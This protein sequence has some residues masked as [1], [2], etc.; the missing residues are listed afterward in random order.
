MRWII[1]GAVIFVVML[2]AGLAWWHWPEGSEETAE[3]SSEATAPEQPAE[4][5]ANQEEVDENLELQTLAEISSAVAAIQQEIEEETSRSPAQRMTDE[6][7]GLTGSV[8]QM[9][10]LVNEMNGLGDAFSQLTG[11][12]DIR[13][14]L[15]AQIN[16]LT[17]QNGNLQN[18]VNTSLD[19]LKTGQ[20]NLSA[21]IANLP[22][23]L[24][25]VMQE[26]FE[27]WK[28]AV[29]DEVVCQLG[30]KFNQLEGDFVKLPQTIAA[31]LE[32]VL[33]AKLAEL[34]QPLTEDQLKAA[35]T[36]AILEAIPKVEAC[37]QEATSQEIILRVRLPEQT[38]EE[39]K[40]SGDTEQPAPCCVRVW[41]Q[42]IPQESGPWEFNCQVH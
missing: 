2:I 41:P 7:T 36:A 40:D 1:G 37:C 18:R 35:A 25:G 27:A 14:S 42:R 4:E 17:E 31:S 28:V 33:A 30:S 9:T 11:E 21:A 38:P 26:E 23:Q 5:E 6:L 3:A 29:A 39:Q 22:D 19:E 34:P 15:Q 20:G 13:D 32:E 10:L 12:K 24:Q 8:E 16:L